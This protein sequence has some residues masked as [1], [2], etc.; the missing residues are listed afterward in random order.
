MGISKQFLLQQAK[1]LETNYGKE[2]FVMNPNIFELWYEMFQDCEEEG[3]R[4]AVNKCLKESEFPPTIAT[5][6]KFYKEL[7]EEREEMR[8]LISHEYGLMKSVWE[9]KDS[10][11]TFK[12]IVDYIYKQP[13]KERRVKMVELSQEGISFYHEL[14][15][16]G[17]QERPTILE[18][19]R[20]RE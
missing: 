19:V 10:A 8:R 18:Y 16:K 11:E 5:L 7:A 12:A 4:L 13:K 15:A 3:L 6:M 2:R 14:I 1:R 9:E 17:I 20:G